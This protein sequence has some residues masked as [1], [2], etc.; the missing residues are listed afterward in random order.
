MTAEPAK[1]AGLHGPRFAANL[2]WLFTDQPMAARFEAAR[3]AGFD[4][5]ELLWPY[6]APLGHW[7]CWAEAAGLPV[8]QINTPRGREAE[9]GL[10]AVPGAEA[11]FRDSFRQAEEA[12]LALGAERI[13]VMA[14]LAEG[15]QAA[16]VFLRNLEWAAGRGMPLAIEP[17]NAADAPG[18]F[19]NDFGQAV[20]VIAALRGAGVGLQF[21]LW[22]ALRITGDAAACW[23]GFGARAVHVQIAGLRDRGDPFG[24]DGFDWNGWL[25]TLVDRDIWISGEYRPARPLR[26]V[27]E[28]L[29]RARR[30]LAGAAPTGPVS[31]VTGAGHQ[32]RG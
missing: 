21:D 15:V 24:A 27:P 2:H 9:M 28:W 7:E 10:A 16:R 32:A 5:V 12:A 6:D 22:H 3:Q 30:L 17:L 8:V 18:Y 20:S 29:R 31:P 23:T 11:R 19:L 13:H 1:R 25:T 4:G 26:A 14:G